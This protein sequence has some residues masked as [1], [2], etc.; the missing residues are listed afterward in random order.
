MNTVNKLQ[1]ASEKVAQ[2]SMAV[3]AAE[4]KPFFEADE[5][6]IFDVAVSADGTWRKRGFKSSGGVVTVI[7]LL[8][9]K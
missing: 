7:S 2:D 5:D 8:S 9:G 1:V 6:E 3:F 4:T